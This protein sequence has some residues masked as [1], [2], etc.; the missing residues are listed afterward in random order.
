M[1][2][3]WFSAKGAER[4]CFFSISTPRIPATVR[5]QGELRS[6]GHTLPLLIAQT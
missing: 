5:Q 3:A 1:S 2:S 4:S 6:N